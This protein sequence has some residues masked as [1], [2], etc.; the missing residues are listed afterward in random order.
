MW[1]M[2]AFQHKRFDTPAEMTVDL[3]LLSWPRP[4]EAIDGG[5]LGLNRMYSDMR[6]ARWS[7]VDWMIKAETAMVERIVRSED[8][9]AEADLIEVE[10]SDDAD[11]DPLGGLD[12]GVAAATFALSAAGC[13]TFTSCN[14]GAFG[15]GW[16]PEAYPLVG[17]YM[18]PRVARAVIE[19]AEQ[20]GAGLFQHRDGYLHVHG[21]TIEAM[22]GFSD[23]LYVRRGDIRRLIRDELSNR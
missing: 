9:A 8:P 18:R 19:A 22:M 21:S 10:A 23:A 20:A 16:H 7:E 4:G 1:G 3:S 17:F 13:V 15:S 2:G 14:A 12:L 5:C 11:G 6:G